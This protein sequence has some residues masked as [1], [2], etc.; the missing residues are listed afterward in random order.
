MLEGK[1]KRRVTSKRLRGVKGKVFY[2]LVKRN[3]VR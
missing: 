3:K 2:K 1:Q